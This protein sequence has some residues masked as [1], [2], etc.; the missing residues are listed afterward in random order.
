MAVLA[1]AC[2]L[3]FFIEQ[4]SKEP[5]RSARLL[6]LHPAILLLGEATHT[7]LTRPS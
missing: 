5:G 1:P 4:A 6:T 2:K 7:K 3:H